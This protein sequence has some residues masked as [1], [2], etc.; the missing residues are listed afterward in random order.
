MKIYKGEYIAGNSFNTPPQGYWEPDT[1]EY[2]PEDAEA[3]AENCIEYV[4]EYLYA[5]NEEA[6]LREIAKA[7][8][9][10]AKCS[11]VDFIELAEQWEKSGII[12]LSEV[13]SEIAEA[14]EE[15]AYL[16]AQEFLCMDR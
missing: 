8:M 2:G 6:D 10:L 4:V 15:A 7:F 3:I 14:E 11:P 9:G 1:I 13:L 5:D 12:D 16:E